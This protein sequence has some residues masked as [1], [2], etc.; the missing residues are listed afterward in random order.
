MNDR[1]SPLPSDVAAAVGAERE[2]PGVDPATRARL[3]AK[4]HASLPAGESGGGHPTDTPAAPRGLSNALRR[5]NP[6]LTGL[7]GFGVGVTI[8]VAV[9]AGFA[10]RAEP[11]PVPRLET[12][13]APALTEP[14]PR[15]PAPAEDE[16]GGAAESPSPAPALS[17][18]EM[19]SPAEAAPPVPSSSTLTAERA[20]LD[21]AHSA[22]GNGQAAEA[23]GALGQHARRF[24]RG[25]YREEREALTIQ[26]FRALGR[27]NEAEQLVATFKA[28]YP[29]SLFLSTIE[30]GTGTNR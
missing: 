7:V 17:G 2:R 24:P 15:A 11:R 9:H 29:R 26:C 14:S 6:L 5:A 27:T 10:G 22:L 8:G 28:R 13:A 4:L 20:L 3:R 18:R 1:P 16:H 25:V 12:I 21:V 19:R 30:P 23:L